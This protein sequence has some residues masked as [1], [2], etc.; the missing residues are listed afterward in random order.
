MSLLTLRGLFDR[1]RAPVSQSQ[2]GHFPSKTKIRKR[3]QNSWHWQK[4]A[5]LSRIF[6]TSR[7]ICQSVGMNL[8]KGGHFPIWTKKVRTK[9]KPVL[10]S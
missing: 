2:N 7:G 6:V 10:I 3:H 8:K 4:S 1:L 5:Q 9:I